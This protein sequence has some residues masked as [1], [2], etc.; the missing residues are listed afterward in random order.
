M[1]RRLA[2]LAGIGLF[3]AVQAGAGELPSRYSSVGMASWYGSDFNGHATADGEIF[4][5]R[6]LSAAHRSLPLPC[7]ARVTNLGNGR[8]VVVRVNDRGPFVGGRI[9]DVSARV[10]KLLEF[11]GLTKVRVDY[12]GKAPPAGSDGSALLASLQA[13]GRP[14]AVKLLPLAATST[15]D[16]G[17]TVI[18]RTV[19]PTPPAGRT[20]P[21]EGKIMLASFVEPAPPAARPGPAERKVAGPSLAAEPFSP[22]GDLLTSPFLSQAARP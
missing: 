2:A 3:G 13:G 5:M 15:H 14:A 9:V 12:V 7:Y 21:D 11:N 8:S 10:A 19:E 1:I 17:N 22:F 6:S 20:A 18:A 4:D 16:E